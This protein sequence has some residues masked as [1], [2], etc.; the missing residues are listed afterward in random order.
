MVLHGLCQV[1]LADG[2]ADPPHLQTAK[3]KSEQCQLEVSPGLGI[4]DAVPIPSSYNLTLTCE[5]L[6]PLLPRWRFMTDEAKA[7][8]K[9]TA[10]SAVVVL[11]A[12]V[13]LRSLLPWI[14]VAVIAWWIWKAVSK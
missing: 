6:M 13:L 7:I 11:V 3:G 12:L 4:H 1:S 10:V 2:A 5:A 9:R 8:T 14:V